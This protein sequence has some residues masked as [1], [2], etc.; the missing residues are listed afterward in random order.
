MAKDT[1]GLNE[2]IAEHA[3]MAKNWRHQTKAERAYAIFGSINEKLFDGELPQPLIGFDDSGRLKKQGEYYYE[4]D[5]LSLKLHFDMRK[6]LKPLDTVVALLHNCV[7]LQQETYGT[8]KSWFHT[9]AFRAQMASWGL[10]CNKNGDVAR[11]RMAIFTNTLKL[12]GQ[13][14]LVD[15]IL[16]GYEIAEAEV[17][18]VEAEGEPVAKVVGAPEVVQFVASKKADNGAKSQKSSL[19]RWSCGCTNVWATV[20]T[21]DYTCNKCGQDVALDAKAGKE[22][23][24]AAS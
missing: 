19:K 5:A 14:E 7:H 3:R 23:S 1:V 13:G 17:T 20:A 24:Y 9:V 6:D 10:E 4:G 15:E 16:E 18:E 12:I 2:Q 21:V 22:A 8:K 11:I